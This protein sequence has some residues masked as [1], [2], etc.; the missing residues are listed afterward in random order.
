MNALKSN[1]LD[2]TIELEPSAIGQFI[3]TGYARSQSTPN[4]TEID[5][6]GSYIN[7]EY[8]A[9]E[10]SEITPS[11][12]AYSFDQAMESRLHARQESAYSS[13]SQHLEVFQ[14]S[15]PQRVTETDYCEEELTTE[16]VAGLPNIRRKR[17]LTEPIPTININRVEPHRPV[18]E[19]LPRHAR[20]STPDGTMIFDPKRRVVKKKSMSPRQLSINENQELNVSRTEQNRK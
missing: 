16:W 10:D 5:E 7:E 14:A 6:F 2:D 4:F 19:T 8:D 20:M 15:T 9:Q 12:T 11:R 17:A 18:V 1:V 3:Q 13:T